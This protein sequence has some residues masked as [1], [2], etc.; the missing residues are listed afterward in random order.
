MTQLATSRI[1]F[2]EHMRNIWYVV[3]EHSTPFEALLD[4]KYWAH[5]SAKFKPRD[6]I[7]VDAE[8]GS[9]F[10][11]LVV[12]DAGRL[13]A[14]VALLRKI[15]L[16]AEEVGSDVSPDFEVKWAGRH[17][18]WRVMRKA[19]KASLKDGFDDRAQAD[20][21]LANHLKAMAA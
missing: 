13:F 10:A 4:S 6:R 5:V 11:E 3:P 9:Y 1:Q 20:L 14:K 16:K 8:D 21:W 17:A 18:K 7:E 12:I 15:E 19:D 2:A